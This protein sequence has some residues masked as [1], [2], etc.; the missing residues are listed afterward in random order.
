MELVV[1]EPTIDPEFQALIPPLRHDEI[2]GLTASIKL[3]GCR[4]PLVVWDAENI[5]LDGHNRL[6][7]C[8]AERI[9]YKVV[10]L[11]FI[12]RDRAKLWILTNQ[13]SR[14]NLTDDQRTGISLRVVEQ[15]TKI[16]KQERARKGRGA[17]GDCKPEEARS[18]WRTT[19]PPSG[20]NQPAIRRNALAYGRTGSEGPERKIRDL[21][22]ARRLW[23]ERRARRPPSSSSAT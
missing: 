22:A 17:G 12:D 23:N 16:E 18:D 2:E 14:R 20:A 15:R 5:L 9:P 3:E 1:V 10:R 4:D 13:L 6:N 8:Q 21:A 7:I 11:N 19:C